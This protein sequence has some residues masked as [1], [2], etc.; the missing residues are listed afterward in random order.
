MILGLCMAIIE[1]L[2]GDM[3]DSSAFDRDT[4]LYIYIEPAISGTIVLL[5]VTWYRKYLIKSYWMLH[6]V[7]KTL[8][9][10]E[11]KVR[12]KPVRVQI[13]IFFFVF[14]FGN[15]IFILHSYVNGKNT[16]HLFYEY[17]GWGISFHIQQIHL[18]Y[19]LVH[20][21]FSHRA[22]NSINDYLNSL[23]RL[24]PGDKDGA[25][26]KLS[27][28]GN[29][30]FELCK[31]VAYMSKMC[32]PTIVLF[33]VRS[34]LV[35]CCS[36]M[37]LNGT[38]PKMKGD[39]FILTIVYVVTCIGVVVWNEIVFTTVSFTKEVEATKF[40]PHSRSDERPLNNMF[41]FTLAEEFRLR[42]VRLE[43][44][45]DKDEFRLGLS[46]IILSLIL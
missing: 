33:S 43:G 8:D 13:N 27:S 37:S 20:M 28:I 22:A 29:L 11:F 35:L 17:L 24:E 19:F 12:T 16:L 26:E 46:I 18:F 38:L 9:E 1:V 39:F 32:S 30:H 44:F 3:S 21:I 6:A 5:V 41:Y 31:S 14:C 25:F 2:Q 15:F 45:K 4:F 10:A 23:K 7:A 34:Y 40:H 36:L 42:R